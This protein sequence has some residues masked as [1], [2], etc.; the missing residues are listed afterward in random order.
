MNRLNVIHDLNKFTVLAKKK[1]F[2]LLLDTMKKVCKWIKFFV[3]CSE[4]N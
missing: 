4:S 1:T 2:F 3:I